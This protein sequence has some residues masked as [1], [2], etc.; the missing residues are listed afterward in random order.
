LKSLGKSI[1]Y[2]IF[3][4][5]IMA[6][7]FVFIAVFLLTE[8]LAMSLIFGAL[9]P[10]SAPAG[11][12]AV[13]YETKAKGPLTRALYAVVGFDDGL[14]IIIF[15]FAA[16]FAENILT[17]EATGKTTELL[18]LIAAPLREIAVSLVIGVVIGR[19]MAS[20]IRRLHESADILSVVAG[21]ILVTCGF[22]TIFHGSL[23]LAN[24]TAGL[25]LTNIRS[26]AEI[27]RIARQMVQ[28]TPLFFILFF[29]FAG[30]KLEVSAL[31]ALGLLGL[32]YILARAGGLLFGAWLGAVIGGANDVI[33]KYLGLGIL[34]QAGVAI[35]LGLIVAHDFAIIG[36][37]HS[38]AIAATVITT[39]TAT[40][41]VFEV[42]GP[43]LTK[44]ALG[45]AGEIKVK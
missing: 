31:S 44:Y 32:V 4:E 16:A 24:M 42:I 14:A 10:A 3:S 38:K 40:S 7:I 26:R 13:I 9:A 21:F 28:V 20:V 35:G 39:V 8:D 27:E 5:S 33:R 36:T 11:T 2:I 25:L 41:I 17:S 19:I 6:F 37:P 12:V 18:T 22:S 15:A 43:I 30:A 29:T 45:K 1:I 23:I 34:S